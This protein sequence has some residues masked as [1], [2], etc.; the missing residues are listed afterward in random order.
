MLT[1]TDTTTQSKTCTPQ[2]SPSPVRCCVF[3]L[4]YQAVITKAAVIGC[5]T[6]PIRLNPTR[7]ENAARNIRLMHLLERVALRFNQAGVPL[8][9]L[10]GAALNLLLYQHPHQREMADLDL[11][12]RPEHLPETLKLLNELGCRPGE[13]F[14]RRDFFPRYY[15][16]TEFLTGDV[17]PAK[18]D[19]HTRPF[20]PLRYARLLPTEAFWADAAT[21]R[22]GQAKLLVPGNEAML[23]HLATHAAIHGE[24]L[25]KWLMDVIRWITTRTNCINWLR[26]LETV[27]HWRLNAPVLRTLA[28]ARSAT[29]IPTGVITRLERMP[30]SWRDRLTLWQA[31]R[32]AKHPA[33]HVLVNALCTPGWR[34]TLSYLR[35]VAVP[36]R[37]HMS[38]WYRRR[39]PGW[40]ICAHLARATR[41]SWAAFSAGWKALVNLARCPPKLPSIKVLTRKNTN[42]HS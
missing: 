24:I 31:P 35:A 34:Y 17:F 7:L 6:Q 36:D 5:S 8:L 16:E 20:R 33:T 26:F 15:Y 11:M 29:N 18:I 1:A 32:D 19:L 37:T 4:S 30:T 12:V 25:G 22:I 3:D 9:A 2:P 39:H 27:Q 10:K 38:T 14:V 40:L 42:I 13:P 23:I 41:P 28:I 21:V